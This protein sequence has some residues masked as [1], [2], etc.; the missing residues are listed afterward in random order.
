[1]QTPDRERAGRGQADDRLRRRPH[2]RGAVAELERAV[3]A[4]A[5][6]RATA[7]RAGV[8]QAGADRGRADRQAGHERRRRRAGWPGQLAPSTVAPARDTFTDDTVGR[9]VPAGHA[10]KNPYPAGEATVNV[11][12]ADVAPTGTPARPATC[13]SSSSTPVGVQPHTG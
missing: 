8:E 13:S 7:E 10:V 12:T 1:M 3:V 4:P 9:A 2:R 6:H 11:N 5:P